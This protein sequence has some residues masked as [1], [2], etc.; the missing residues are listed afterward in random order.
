MS[1]KCSCN[2]WNPDD[3]NFCRNCGKQMK[4]INNLNV[5]STEKTNLPNYTT[6][7]RREVLFGLTAGQIFLVLVSIGLVI[8]AVFTSG[9]S[10]A[11]LAPCAYVISKNWDTI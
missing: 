4:E 3:A 10:L 1:I 5:D 2:T 7:S 11:A 8:A 9:I 6:S